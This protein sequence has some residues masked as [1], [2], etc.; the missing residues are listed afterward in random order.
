MFV[1]S[2]IC[3]STAALLFTAGQKNVSQSGR[4][5]TQVPQNPFSALVVPTDKTLLAT[6]L[7][8]HDTYDVVQ[9]NMSG[10]E[11]I[12]QSLGTTPAQ[13]GTDDA[14]KPSTNSTAHADV[15]V[16][17]QPTAHVTPT[18]P[19]H[20]ASTKPKPS[21]PLSSRGDSSLL[22]GSALGVEV[23]QFAQRFIGTPYVWGGQS[24]Q[25]FDCSG[26]VKYTYQHFGVTLNRSSFGQFD[27]GTSVS[28]HDLMPGDLVFFSTDGP[29]ASHVGI[30]VGGSRFI[31]AAGS[32]VRI[33]SLSTGYWGGHYIGARHL[34]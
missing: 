9:P 16:H 10:F 31:N 28:R 4:A 34:H 20:H 6:T 14:K 13:S 1:T 19:V 22:P 24:P 2:V 18:P 23:T 26:F 33:D 21:K 29:G 30:Y 8:L 5:L 15:V 27:Q 17:P 7:S 25:G 3:L 11:Q 12:Q 32:S